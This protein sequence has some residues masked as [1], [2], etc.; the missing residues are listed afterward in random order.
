M[1]GRRWTAALIVTIAWAATLAPAR[2]I[3]Q[4]SEFAH[5]A[6]NLVLVVTDDQR[7]DTLWAMPKLRSNLIDRGITFSNAFAENPACCPSRASILTGQSSHTTGVWRNIPPF[8]GYKSFQDSSTLATWLDASGY[9]TALVGKYFNGYAGAT[10]VPPGWDRWVA[11]N[12]GT[13]R[14]FDYKL[15]VDGVTTPYGTAEG[16]YSTDVLASYASTFIRNTPGDQPLFLTFTPNAPHGVARGTAL[17]G[18][19]VPAPRHAD[20]FP[21]LAPWRPPSWNEQDTSDKPAHMRDLEEVH[22][23]RFRHEQLK[24]LLAIDDA[25]ERIVGALRDAGRL[26]NTMIVFTSDNGLLW[27]EHRWARKLVPYEES[28]RIPLVIRY[29]PLTAEARTES[30]LVSTIDL[31]PT[32]AEAAGVAAPDVDG[33]SLMPILAGLDPQWRQDLLVEHMQGA[34]E[35]D[36]V[37][38]YCAVRTPRHL[39]AVYATGEREL[40][41]LF[42]DPYQLT[43]VASDPS[44]AATVDSLHRRLLTLCE[45]PPPGLTLPGPSVSPE[46][47]PSSA[48]SLVPSPSPSLAPSPSPEPSPAPSQ[49]PSGD[50]SPSPSR[51][52]LPSSSPNS[53]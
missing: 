40:Y 29:D 24:S 44:Q 12:G 33:L 48:P 17:S 34:P 9:R 21:S 4:S 5:S 10:Y 2:A 19:P 43:N 45:P 15:N 18:P 37:K 52:P 53:G 31:A 47:S 32:L 35:A 28:I 30:R 46:P 51:Q 26:G 25:I 16:D 11:L 36:S 1:T 23:D 38:T 3:R 8:G 41:D 20:A 22:R 50:P 42:Q 27:G 6:P 13:Y 7:W 49:L 14:Y 39:Y